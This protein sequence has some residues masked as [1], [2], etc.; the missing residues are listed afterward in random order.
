MSGE[1]IPAGYALVPIEPTEAMLVA[2][3]RDYDPLG[4]LI[5]WCDDGECFRRRDLISIY[6]QMIKAAQ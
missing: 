3:L 4:M 1:A 6:K 5:D 2:G